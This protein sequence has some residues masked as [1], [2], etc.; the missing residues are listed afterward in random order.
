MNKL[1]TI[2]SIFDKHED[3]IKLQHKSIIKNIKG[4]YE[5]IVFNNASCPLQR[6]KNLEICNELNIKCI[7]ILNQN[8]TLDPSGIAGNALNEAF[9]HL[10]DKIVLKIDSDMFFIN[11]F[12]LSEILNE[13][14]L[15]YIPNNNIH[16]GEY[17]WS[18]FFAIDLNKVKDD[19]NFLPGIVQGTDT[20][21]QSINLINNSSYTKK[22]VGLLNLQK[23]ENTVYTAS[24]N[25]ECLFVFNSKN[26]V[27]SIEHEYKIK[28]ENYNN[29][30]RKLLKIENELI[31]NN[32]PEPYFIDIIY[33]N[34]KEFIFHFK[35]SNWCPWYTEDYVTLKK[36]A[37]IKLLDLINV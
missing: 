3:F 29:I 27:L 16:V 17:A 1:I 4:N 8:Y 28:N 18:G 33:L 34:N 10:K 22:R 9:K 36:Q 15:L 32:F 24:I 12:N 20:F 25:N 26:E 2:C 6:N 30:I 35:S 19:I 31:N 13:I 11:E 21:G 7:D 14:D 5:Y 23:K 37:L